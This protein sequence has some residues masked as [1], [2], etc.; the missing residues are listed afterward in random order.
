M[1]W[2]TTYTLGWVL[3]TTNHKSSFHPHLYRNIHH[4]HRPQIHHHGDMVSFTLLLWNSPFCNGIHLIVMELVWKMP[5]II[6]SVLSLVQIS[7]LNIFA[8]S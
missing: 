4:Q 3:K 7:G 5:I 6:D 2:L 1:H 8:K